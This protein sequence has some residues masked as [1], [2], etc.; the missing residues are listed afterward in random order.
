MRHSA[1]SRSFSGNLDSLKVWFMV[2]PIGAAAIGKVF[3][4]GKSPNS[5]CTMGFWRFQ[6]LVILCRPRAVP[7]H[8]KSL[9]NLQFLSFFKKKWCWRS[10][11]EVHLFVFRRMLRLILLFLVKNCLWV[12]RSPKGYQD[13]IWAAICSDMGADFHGWLALET[14]GW[15]F[16]NHQ[17]AGWWIANHQPA[18]WWHANNQ[19]AGWWLC[20][21]VAYFFAIHTLFCHE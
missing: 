9:K 20:L 6:G 15:W 17:L 21:D 18:G 1:R 2:Y 11:F 14:A 13:G 5:A 16:A 19:P 8:A 10:S 7:G 3:S 12:T 4:Q